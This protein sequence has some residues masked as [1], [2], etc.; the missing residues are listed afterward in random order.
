MEREL[1]D[2]V[3]AVSPG[4]F[5]ALALEVFRFQYDH[6]PLYRR[7]ADALHRPKEA[8]RTLRSIPFLPIRF[9]KSHQIM[10]TPFRPETV[11]ESSGTTGSLN[12]RHFVKDAGIY[13]HSFTRAFEHFYGSPSNWCILG[14]LPSYLERSG[15]S[16][17]LMAEDLIRMSGHPDSGFYIHEHEK[18]YEV[19]QRLEASGQPVLLLGVTFGLLD[20]AEKYPLQLRHTL[21]METGG[22]KGRRREMTRQEL[23]E[24]LQQSWGVE[25]IHAEYGMTELLSQ[26]YSAGNG[27]YEGPDWMQ[28]L[29]RE[30]EDPLEVQDAA[31]LPARGSSGVLNLIDLANLYSCAFIATDDL[32]KLY[33]DGRFEVLG[34]IDNSDI[35]GCSQ[36]LL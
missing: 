19:L 27:V 29:I 18:L 8:V 36:L 25:V 35:R 11:F 4:Q 22:M 33:P 13:R 15:S 7:Y 32:G 21:V 34:R 17:T 16:L 5:E 12:S 24:T 3:F 23:H 20:F 30:E 10:T 26:A 1:I 9:F 2:K 14:L 31:G 6:N 28:A